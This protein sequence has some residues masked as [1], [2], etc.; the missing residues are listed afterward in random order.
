MD[1]LDLVKKVDK[2]AEV[3]S[4]SAL[5][6]PMEFI[7]TGFYIVNACISGSLFGGIPNRITTV[8]G[9]PG[10]GKSFFMLSCAREAQ[11]KGYTP[12]VMD[13]EYAIDETFCV[14]LGIDPDH[15]IIRPTN[16][17]SD[18]SEFVSKLCDELEKED[19]EKRP[20]IMLILDSLSNLTSDDEKK[21]AEEGNMGKRDFTK[22]LQLKAFFR[23]VT[24]RLGMLGIPM[25]LSTH[26]YMSMD[27]FS[28]EKASGG[29]GLQFSS[30]TMLMLSASKLN[31]DD[32]ENDKKAGDNKD[33]V[34][35][36]INVMCKPTK[37]RFTKPIKV[38]FH[39]PYFKSPNPYV[40]L[41]NY[42]TWEN[43]GI[44]RGKCLTE[45]EVSKLSKGDQNKIKPFD[46]EDETLYF[47]PGDRARSIVVSHLGRQVPLNRF[48]TD[49]VFTDEFLHKIDDEIIKPIFSL[50][51]RS[52]TN[53][54]EE[55]L[56]EDEEED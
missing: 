36:G 43:S 10:S 35:T 8:S 13:T 14:R 26:T 41:E 47:L 28:V 44:G 52:S 23:V 24:T 11:K 9:S 4:D 18:M 22:Q 51:D 15:I 49:E 5:S 19:E 7:D 32:K 53:D 48:Y 30:S 38:R 39:I 16:T 3:L 6:K 25:M 1:I 54:I 17:I 42:L 20:K 55:Y 29:M 40:G 27:F 46:Y 12:I 50:P 45:E 34:K 2:G 33:L 21:N 56:D 31:G 37:S